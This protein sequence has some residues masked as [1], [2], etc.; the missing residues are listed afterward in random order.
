MDKALKNAIMALPE[1]KERIKKLQA[2][3]TEKY[4][5][6]GEKVTVSIRITTKTLANGKED[7]TSKALNKKFTDLI[8]KPLY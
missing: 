5:I 2:Y 6:S 3:A 4:K 7:E 1:M 8:S